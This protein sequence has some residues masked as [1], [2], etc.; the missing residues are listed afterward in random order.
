LPKPITPNS[1]GFALACIDVSPVA[2]LLATQPDVQNT[3]DDQAGNPNSC[4]KAAW[5]DSDSNER[6]DRA[7]AAE[8]QG[9][10]SMMVPH[11]EK[12]TDKGDNQGRDQ[13]WNKNRIFDQ[14]SEADRRDDRHKGGEAEATER[15]EQRT[16][17]AD[18]VEMS[19]PEPA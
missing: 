2:K 16:A 19:L 15:C 10:G 14:E 6:H 13:K 18:L 1:C 17:N 9:P 5:L 12:Q 11:P 3:R 4:D 8:D 7:H